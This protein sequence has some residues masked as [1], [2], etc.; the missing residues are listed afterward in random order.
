MSIGKVMLASVLLAFSAV[1]AAQ[2][3]VPADAIPRTPWGAPD[4]QGVYDFGT[5]IPLQRPVDFGDRAV[6]T[7]EEIA[8]L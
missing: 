6:L 4:L 5:A 7:D 2:S 3:T 8:V 1:S